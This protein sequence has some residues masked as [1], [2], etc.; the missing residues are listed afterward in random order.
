MSPG[1]PRR[2]YGRRLGP[3]GSRAWKSRRR[4]GGASRDEQPDREDECTFPIHSGPSPVARL[5]PKLVS[6]DE[7]VVWAM[8]GVTVVFAFIFFGLIVAT[9]WVMRLMGFAQ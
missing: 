9:M 4:L 8:L 1:G 2:N 6:V 7:T 3:C 5:Q